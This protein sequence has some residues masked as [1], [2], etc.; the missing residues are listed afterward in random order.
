MAKPLK[1]RLVLA[2]LI[3]LFLYEYS[4][5]QIN[6]FLLPADK[7]QMTT[8][9]SNYDN[10]VVI[11]TVLQDSLTLRLILDSGIEGI[12]IT[13]P[14]LVSYFQ[15]SCIRNFKLSAPGTSVVLNAC[16]TPL[17]KVKVS[18][19]TPIFSNIIL[20][21]DDL[22]SL[23]SFIGSK[24]HG[25]IGIDKFRNLVLSINYDNNTIKFTKPE[26]YHVP[27]NSQVLSL[28]ILRGRPY[29]TARVSLDNGTTRDLWLMIDSGANHPLLLETDSTDSYQPVNSLKTTIGRG[30]GGN[31]PGEFVRS[32]WL[33]LGNFRLDNILTSISSEYFVSKQATRNYRH[34]TIGSGTLSRFR[35]SFDYTNNRLILNKGAKFN[36]PFEYNMSGITFESLSTD[37]NLF[38]V[39][40]IIEGSPADEAGIKTGDMLININGKSAFTLTLGELNAI[41]SSKPG[42]WINLNVS[43]QG[44]PLYMKFR[45]KRLI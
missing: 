27:K 24:V 44:K 21:Q 29:L 19:L 2:I 11:E 17:L 30:L 28:N 5:A 18:N 35:V 43:R 6:S 20:L 38:K 41:L 26:F 31:I 1:M 7:K 14:T 39:S 22:I 25:L 32:N 10:M 23:E 13:D 34:G 36:R 16:F 45:L 40:E 42:T 12:V 9:F 37:F 3:F 8:R 15:S 33:M 4:G